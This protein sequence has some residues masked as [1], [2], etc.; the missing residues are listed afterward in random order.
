MQGLWHEKDA[1]VWQAWTKRVPQALQ[2]L[3]AA[4]SHG[5][6]SLEQW[7]TTSLQREVRKRW[8]KTS[9]PCLSQEELCKTLQWRALR[10]PLSC[11]L[12]NSLFFQAAWCAREL[13]DATRE[14]FACLKCRQSDIEAVTRLMRL[15]GIG[16]VEAS[17]VLSHVCPESY[18]FMSS[19]AAAVATGELSPSYA[20]FSEVM[21]AKAKKLRN[22]LPSDVERALMASYVLGQP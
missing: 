3:E 8:A 16:P 12:Q 10:D 6:A 5:L 22:L 11:P 19:P 15:P 1:N 14:S 20:H 4:G 9:V 13:Q 7:L 2:A 21:L 17:A 18:A